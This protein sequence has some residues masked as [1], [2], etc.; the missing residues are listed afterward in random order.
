MLLS[1]VFGILGMVLVLIMPLMTILINKEI[2]KYFMECK[3]KKN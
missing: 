2:L 1:M 3:L